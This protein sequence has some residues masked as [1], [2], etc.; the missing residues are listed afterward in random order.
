L[1]KFLN[2]QHSPESC[3]RSLRRFAACPPVGP[4]GGNCPDDELPTI[5]RSRSQ[6]SWKNLVS[7]QALNWAFDRDVRPSGAKF[8]LVCLAN[9]VDSEGHCWTSQKRLAVD[10]NQSDRSVRQHLSRLEEI[11]LIRRSQRRRKDGTRAADAFDLNWHE[12]RWKHSPV[13]DEPTGISRRTNRKIS[14]VQPEDL[15]GQEP[16]KEP[17]KEPSARARDT[18]PAN[19]RAARACAIWRQHEDE[20]S[21]L[22]IWDVWLKHATPQHHDCGL[23]VLAV[24]TQLFRDQIQG[25]VAEIERIV[26][27]KVKIV[28]K[29]FAVQAA[30]RRERPELSQTV[31]AT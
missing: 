10:T 18:S 26:Q 29:P 8:I 15:A 20:L 2:V 4:V 3:K 11:G 7:I 31:K 21:R 30:R 13:E 22:E 6:Q 14:P 28:I 12:D 9:R 16:N 5:A 17:N 23:L 19:G 25:H 1:Y 27:R 24:S